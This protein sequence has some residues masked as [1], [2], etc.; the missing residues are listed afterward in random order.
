MPAFRKPFTAM[1][2]VDATRNE[3]FTSLLTWW[4]VIAW[5]GCVLRNFSIS[6]LYQFVSDLNKTDIQR[7][8]FMGRVRRE[9]QHGHSIIASQSNGFQVLGVWGVAI[10]EE[11]VLVVH[12]W[13]H[14]LD[15]VFEPHN[16]AI[17]AN[18]TWVRTGKDC[19]GRSVRV[20]TVTGALSSEH[21][22]GRQVIANPRVTIDACCRWPTLRARCNTNLTFTFCRQQK[23]AA[24]AAVI[25][26]CQVSQANV[27]RL[28][29]G[30]LSE[31]LL[32]LF[33]H[34]SKLSRSRLS[35]NNERDGRI[36]WPLA[37]AEPGKSRMIGVNRS[38]H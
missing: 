6:M 25:T 23:L 34:G 22:H 8:H 29:I 14:G 20:Q 36:Y 1:L 13:V 9:W 11:Q 15:E 12:R 18:P 38:L 33:S 26:S 21:K 27:G 35:K 24:V 17:V 5:P 28:I 37:R 4:T 7:L 16:K 19:S 2:M 30:F 32:L 31:G 10:Q 3:A